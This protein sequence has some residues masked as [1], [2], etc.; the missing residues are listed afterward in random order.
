[1]MSWEYNELKAAREVVEKSIAAAVESGI[2]WLIS[3][4]ASIFVEAIPTGVLN[5]AAKL[6]GPPSIIAA[7]EILPENLPEAWK[8]DVSSGL[9]IATVLSVKGGKILPWKT[10][11]DVITSALHARFLELTKDS[12]TWPCDFPSAEFVRLKMAAGPSG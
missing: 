3:G 5:I 10:V 4:P 8:D 6:C 1:M 11:R 12:Q 9:S 7:A 2:M